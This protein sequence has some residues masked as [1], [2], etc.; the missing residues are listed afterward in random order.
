MLYRRC[1]A[2]GGGIRRAQGTWGFY[3]PAEVKPRRKNSSPRPALGARG[4]RRSSRA[5]TSLTDRPSGERVT[6]SLLAVVLPRF[7]LG[8]CASTSRS[9][10]VH[11]KQQWLVASSVG[12]TNSGRHP[13]LSVSSPI[14]RSP[15]TGFVKRRLRSQ[16]GGS[17]PISRTASWT[18]SPPLY[19]SPPPALYA[20]DSPWR[21]LSRLLPLVR[22]VRRVG[23]DRGEHRGEGRKV[24]GSGRGKPGP[25]VPSPAK[26]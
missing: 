17:E 1:A 4:G 8:C 5:G 10:P 12:V 9:I 20:H 15:V 16:V 21:P 22:A 18:G 7:D 13:L 6:R 11:H 26:V 19:R 25:L 3:E 2:E 14:A 23:Q 24:R